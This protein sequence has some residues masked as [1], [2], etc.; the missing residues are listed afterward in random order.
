[1]KTTIKCYILLRGPTSE[2]DVT[3]NDSMRNSCQHI[4]F[5]SPTHNV[6]SLLTRYLTEAYIPYTAELAVAHVYVVLNVGDSVQCTCITC[7]GSYH[8][9]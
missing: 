4:I 3:L 6:M 9:W 5:I 8:N 1:M 2:Q 7:I